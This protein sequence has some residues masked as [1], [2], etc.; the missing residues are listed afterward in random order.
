MAGSGHSHMCV[1]LCMCVCNAET[2]SSEEFNRSSLLLGEIRKEN[3]DIQITHMFISSMLT[4]YLMCVGRRWYC[5]TV[6]HLALLQ[7]S[8]KRFLVEYECVPC[9]CMVPSRYSSFLPQSKYIQFKWTGD[10]KMPTSVNVRV[11]SVRFEW[12]LLTKINKFKAS[13]QCYY[14][15]IAFLLRDTASV[16]LIKSIS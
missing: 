4:Y 11:C 7:H 5:G 14:T 2:V 16:E 6:Q 9:V 15:D 12:P 3:Q 8:K 10:S 13:F 1:C